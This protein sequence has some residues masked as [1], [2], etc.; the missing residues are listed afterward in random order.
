MMAFGDQRGFFEKKPL[1][2]PKKLDQM[3]AKY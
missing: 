2:K 3:M 1:W